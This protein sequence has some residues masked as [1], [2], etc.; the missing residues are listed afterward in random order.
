MRR[1]CAP[2]I[3]FCKILSH[4]F[5]RHLL[6]SNAVGDLV[7][8]PGMISSENTTQSP[9]D[10]PNQPQIP[11]VCISDGIQHTVPVRAQPSICLPWPEQLLQSSENQA[12]GFFVKCHPNRPGLRA[13]K[14]GWN[15]R[16]AG[17][18]QSTRVL[19]LIRTSV[20]AEMLPKVTTI[21]TNHHI[22]TNDLSTCHG[23]RRL[24]MS[25]AGRMSAP[26]RSASSPSVSWYPA[27]CMTWYFRRNS[28]RAF[29]SSPAT[30]SGVLSL[31]PWLTEL[32][33]HALPA[34]PEMPHFSFIMTWILDCRE[35]DRALCHEGVD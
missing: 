34:V 7:W 21:G 1:L 20:Q 11:L 35:L 5:Q 23:C 12:Q 8:S 31:P 26:R 24:G 28:A 27:G 16:V 33:D 6:C 29:Q 22:A 30:K 2:G 19:L 14:A 13:P 15:G 25:P 18:A 4:L 9:S 32:I 10:V 17:L 3:P